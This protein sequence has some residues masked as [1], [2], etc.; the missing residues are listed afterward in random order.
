MTRVNYRVRAWFATQSPLE[1]FCCFLWITLALHLLDLGR[2]QPGV[3]MPDY[4][5]EDGPFQNLQLALLGWAL[6]LCGR[7][8]RRHQGEF[9]GALVILLGPCFF[10][11]WREA[12]WDKDHVSAWLGA[13]G[14]R[15]FSWRYLT[16]GPEIP[17]QLKVVLGTISVGLAVAWG[18]LCWRFRT[19]FRILLQF[20][21]ARMV[22]VWLILFLVCLSLAQF[23]DRKWLPQEYHPTVREPYIEEAPELLGEL[24]LLFAVM[25]MLENMRK[26][27]QQVHEPGLQRAPRTRPAIVSP[28]ESGR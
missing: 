15:M 10:L 6:L 1:V 26:S 13:E 20:V 21:R 4:L 12:D 7:G 11:F 14:V 9:R 28:A 3:T 8:I 27:V 18:F 23:P 25:T 17:L 2:L 16:A 19:S 5:A 22:S 24:A